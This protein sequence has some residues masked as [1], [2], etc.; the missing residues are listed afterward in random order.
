MRLCAVSILVVPAMAG[1]CQGCGPDPDP[2]EIGVVSIDTGSQ[3]TSG[4]SEG[5]GHVEFKGGCADVWRLHQV[6]T[7]APIDSWIVRGRIDAPEGWDTG[8]TADSPGPWVYVAEDQANP[9]ITGWTHVEVT[10]GP[11]P[12]PTSQSWTVDVWYPL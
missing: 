1:P 12:D 11:V 10:C 4:P 3:D 2:T 8:A 5:W 9:T 6:P 7:A